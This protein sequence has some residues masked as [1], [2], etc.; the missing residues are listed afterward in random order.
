MKKPIISIV[1]PVYNEEGN[2]APFFVELKKWVPKSHPAEYIF[3]DDGSTD[4]TLTQIKKLSK[5]HPEIKYLSFTRNFGHQYALKAGLDYAQ[6]KAVISLDGDFQHP[7]SIIPIMIEKWSKGDYKI[8]YTERVNG[9]NLGWLKK[10][11]SK[12]FYKLINSMSDS[13]IGLGR[14]DFRLLDRQVV[15]LIIKSTESTLFLRG[16]VAWTGHKN[17]CIPY[18]QDVRIWGK[19]KYTYSKMIKLAVDAIT[20]FTTFP[21]RIA[22]IVGL[23]MSISSGLYGL[24][25]IMTW[26]SNREVILGW[27][28]VIV[29]ILF[30]GGIQLLILGIVGEYIGKIFLE[31][32][33][34]PLYLIGESKL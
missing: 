18:E 8:V 21:L 17:I 9:G 5:K 28:S 4:K 27:S 10:N 24:Y 20:S 22:S 14:A 34:R 23:V 19:S 30:I 25:A 32:K 15:D 29:S 26:I 13:Q 3:I 6:G 16:L 33:N 2:I 7:P 31:T 12:L 1:I 11:T